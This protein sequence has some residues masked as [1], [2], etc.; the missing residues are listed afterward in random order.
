MNTFNINITFTN[1]TYLN[2]D[3]VKP[4]DVSEIIRLTTIYS[5]VSTINITRNY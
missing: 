3:K 4:E 2:F 5:D 1:S